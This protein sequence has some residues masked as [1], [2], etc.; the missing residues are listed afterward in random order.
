LIQ[1][2]SSG[3]GL[4]G[5]TWRIVDYSNNNDLAEALKGIHTVLSFINQSVDPGNKAQKSLIDASV[6]AGVKRF[7]PSE[8]GW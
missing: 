5:P 4:P 2:S 7:A 3:N 6:A 8:Y 1:E